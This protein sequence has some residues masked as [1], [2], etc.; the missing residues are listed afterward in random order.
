MDWNNKKVSFHISNLE[1]GQILGFGFFPFLCVMP[2][3]C[4]VL[5]LSLLV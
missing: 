5:F 4:E 3:L 1:L 2:N